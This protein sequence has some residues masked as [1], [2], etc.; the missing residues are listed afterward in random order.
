MRNNAEHGKFVYVISQFLF[1]GLLQLILWI[2]VGLKF[3]YIRLKIYKLY[4]PYFYLR[5]FP[6]AL[7]ILIVSEW[8][9]L[10]FLDYTNGAPLGYSAVFLVLYAFMVVGCLLIFSSLSRNDIFSNKRLCFLLIGFGSLFIGMSIRDIL[11]RSICVAAFFIYLIVNIATASSDQSIFQQLPLLK[12]MHNYCQ[13]LFKEDEA[14]K[15]HWFNPFDFID[16]SV[17]VTF[18]FSLFIVFFPLGENL[19]KEIILKIVTIC[20]IWF[21]VVTYPFAAGMLMRY[22]WSNRILQFS[23]AQGIAYSLTQTRNGFIKDLLNTEFFTTSTA[24][25][26]TY[27]TSQ[28]YYEQLYGKRVLVKETTVHHETKLKNEEYAFSH[29]NDRICYGV[30]SYFKIAGYVF[31]RSL[32]FLISPF[33]F[34]SLFF[35]E[36]IRHS[37]T[38]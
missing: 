18:V 2:S 37:I 14:S 33:L 36:L 30:L 13:Q 22:S 29:T 8:M 35:F 27:T 23:S 19:F 12:N 3:V 24:V 25:P 21:Y 4:Q 17:I 38:R 5:V 28:N 32:I 11:P 6:I 9:M 34:P 15:K 10:F 7:I 26:Y 16:E 31:L 1:A 20:L